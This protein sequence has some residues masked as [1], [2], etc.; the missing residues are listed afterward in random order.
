ML[1][2]SL[3]FGLKEGIKVGKRA[4]STLAKHAAEARL[5]ADETN[6]E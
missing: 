5:H 6:E 4:E 3:E 1:A 2:A